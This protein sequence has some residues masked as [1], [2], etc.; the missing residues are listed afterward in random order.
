M[1]ILINRRI[2]VLY[3]APVTHCV[4]RLCVFPATS[5]AGQIVQEQHW[6]CEPK[7]QSARE[8]D[9]E[10]GNRIL[11]IHH[12][13][14]SRSFKFEMQCRVQRE[15]KSTPRESGLAPTGIG[16]FLLPSAL[17]DLTPDI[18]D[19]TTKSIY[20]VGKT[21][22]TEQKAAMLCE[23]VYRHL[24]YFEGATDTQT[25]ASQV[26]ARSNGVCQ[27]FAHLMIALC[28]AAQVPAR[29][30]SGYSPGE[31][32]MHAW[33][34]V[35]CDGFWQAWDPTHNRRGRLCD[36]VVATGRDY[37]DVAPISGT[38]RGHAQVVLQSHCATQIVAD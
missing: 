30:V 5:R 18:R 13:R 24:K 14:I 20:S 31:G 26:W 1:Q 12:N 3:S 34:E 35:L 15:D 37:R 9:D 22:S 7:P 28:R 32:R 25:T 21:V 38:Y 8:Y 10:M 17:C 2:K 6:Q 4:R 11:E 16:A 29:Y 27:D 23:A 33:V 19:L 36:V